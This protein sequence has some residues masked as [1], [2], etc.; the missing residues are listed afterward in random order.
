MT[1][2][3]AIC[4]ATYKRPIGLDRLLTSLAAVEVPEGHSMTVIVVDNDE[5]GSARSVVD[6]VRPRLDVAYDVEARQGIPFVRN[7][8]TELALERGADLLVFVDDDEWADPDWLRELVAAR[9]RH[10]API[11]SGYVVAEFEE[12]PPEWAV[13]VGAYQR[14]TWPDGHELDYAIT[15]NVLVDA[16]VLAGDTRPFDESLR[17]SGGSDLQLFHRLHRAGHRIVFAPSARCHELIPASRVDEA[18][19]LKRQYRRG[20]NRSTTLRSVDF[21]PATVAKRL[22]ASLVEIGAGL[23]TMAIGTFRGD[24]RRL[25][26]RMRVSYGTGLAVGL[27][28]RHY[29]EYRTTHG[30]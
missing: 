4:V 12:D 8:G 18:W 2:D 29:E 5:E 24:I 7:R 14:K 1:V 10:G 26:G 3:I 15:A 9:A 28:G 27:T 20:V 19:V 17:Y 11:V 21:R 23:A 13:E 25:R 16:T 6:E 30:S 22:A